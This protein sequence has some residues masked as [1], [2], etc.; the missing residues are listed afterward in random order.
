M[1]L[2]ISTGVRNRLAQGLG[3]GAIFNRG[4]LAIYSGPQPASGD[5]AKTGTLLG[6]ITESAGTLT[7]ETRATGTIVIT[8]ATSGSINT[9]TV[10]TFNIIP[11]GAVSAVAG[12]TAATASALA[13][14][15]NRNGIFEAS[16]SASTVTI[17][18]KY[19]VGAAWNGLA[20]TATLTTVTA[21]YGGG[22]VASGVAPVNGLILGQPAAGVIAKLSTQVWSMAGLAIGTA[23]WFRLYGSEADAG[24]IV[25]G[26]P[27]YP[28]LDGSVAVSGADLNL[29]NISITVGAPVSIDTFSFTIP[30][31]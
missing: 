17:S 21:T 25:S 13:D 18:A 4:S 16:V 22:T 7:Q 24:A 9:V 23:G 10:G 19:G 27:Y 14:A 2:R 31:A 26:A 30:A 15:I 5:A 11:D 1:T 28:R 8:G 3:F 20:L 12:D 6:L 29:S